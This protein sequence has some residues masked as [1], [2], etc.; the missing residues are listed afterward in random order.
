MRYMYN[1]IVNMSRMHT[2]S[3]HDLSHD[4][5]LFYSFFFFEKRKKGPNLLSKIKKVPRN[6]RSAMK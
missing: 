1:K 3:E 6:I 5:F 4:F 2:D